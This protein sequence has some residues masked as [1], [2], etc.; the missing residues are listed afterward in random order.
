[1]FRDRREGRGGASISI[2]LLVRKQ[3]SVFPKIYIQI[4]RVGE[5]D[6]RE[7]LIYCMFVKHSLLNV[8]N[9]TTLETSYYYCH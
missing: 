6:L 5:S 9:G 7:P 2:E 4:H 8:S 1:M 3:I